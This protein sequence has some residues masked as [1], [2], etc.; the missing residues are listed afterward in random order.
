MITVREDTFTPSENPSE[1]DIKHGWNSGT[2]EVEFN[3]KTRRVDCLAPGKDKGS[4]TIYGLCARYA[5][6]SKVWR[7]TIYWI[8]NK[9][10]HVFTG[11]E[12]RTGRYSQPRI[13]GF[14]QDVGEAHVS[15][16]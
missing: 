15:K 12:N 7:A 9:I 13:C 16:R 5:T 10:T 4:W 2:V 14:T 3:G 11:F 1:Y 6:G 8:D